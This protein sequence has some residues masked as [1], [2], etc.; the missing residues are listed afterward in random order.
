MTKCIGIICEY[1]PFHNGHLYHLNK[2][3]EIFPDS[4]I[5][6]VLNGY[7]NQ[8]GNLSIMAKDQKTITALNHNVDLVIELPFVFGTQSSDI[9]ASG[10]IQILK[11]LKVDYLVF[12]SELND[13]KKLQHLVDVQE[14]NE[15]ND[16]VK[17][18]LDS[19][20]NYPTAMSKALKKL[21][22]TEI[23]TPN[24]LL[25]LS[26]IKAIK[27][28]NSTIIPYSIKRTNDYHSLDTNNEIISGSAIRNLL[29]GNESI[30]KYV[31]KDINDLKLQYNDLNT[32]FDLI[33][34][35]IINEQ[36]N[37]CKYQ[38][39][40]EGIEYR[41]L[42]Y[43]NECNN[44]EELIKKVKTKRYTYNKIQRMLI[45][46]LCSFTKEE[47]KENKNIEYIR[48]LG[49]NNNG[50]NYLSKI[51]KEIST[52]IISKLSNQHFKQLDIENRV[53]N[54]FNIK[55]INKVNEYKNFPIYK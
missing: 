3:K 53:T 14:T 52:P 42:K 39:V 38:T 54:I 8:R 7:F 15:Y 50:R 12:G 32:Y 43:I 51:K 20:I 37:I 47:A 9:F 16:L 46:I 13:V 45:H 10:A 11:E 31:P 34:Y 19:G 41:L 30:N 17:K 28:L 23:T 48:I 49:F 26:Y 25:G 21:T 1:N 24:D 35:K 33:K 27:E 36:E 18:Q 44:I 4:L 2:I 22:Q 29:K 40:D 6:L 5:I 55:Q